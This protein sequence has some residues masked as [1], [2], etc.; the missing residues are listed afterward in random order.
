MHRVAVVAGCRTPFARAGS[1][2]AGL[3][4]VE[5]GTIAVR[6][7]LQRGGVD[8]KEID[9]VV[10]G[11]VVAIHSGAERSARGRPGRRHP[12]RGTRVHRGPG[13]CLVE[14]GHHLGRRHHR[15]RLRRSHGRGWGR[16]A[17]RRANA[18]LP[19]AA[20]RAARRIP[21]PHPGRPPPGPRRREAPRPGPHRPRHSRAVHRRDHGPERGAHGQGERHQPRGAGPLGAPHPPAGRPG[22]GR[23]PAHGRDRACRSSP[24]TTTMCWTA[25][26]ASARTPR[27]RNWRS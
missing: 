18:A 6:E 25:T 22:H 5:L 10:Y 14:P 7:L 20:R 16:G 19:P 17:L 12:A 23:R 15:A 11:T 8:P 13:L 1:A 21:G 27:S 9:E 2:L 24:R 3:S 4:A 26:T